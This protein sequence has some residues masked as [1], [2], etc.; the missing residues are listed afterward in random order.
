MFLPLH[1][2]SGGPEM[3]NNHIH[4][5]QQ[6]FIKPFLWARKSLIV[7]VREGVGVMVM[8]TMVIKNRVTDLTDKIRR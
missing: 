6:M 1:M 5:F 8:V 2:V 4:L 7:C 3:L